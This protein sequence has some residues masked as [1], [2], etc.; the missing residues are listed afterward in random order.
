MHTNMQRAK[1]LLAQMSLKEKIAQLVSVWFEIA[2]DESITIRQ[3]FSHHQHNPLSQQEILQDGIGQLSRP[4]GT[5][6][7]DV[8]KQAASVN[9]IQKYI[10][11]STRLGIP[12]MF[13]EECL[14]GA[15]VSGATIFPSALN[16]GS[17]W[18]QTLIKEIATR[19]GKELRSLNVH[20]GLSPVLDVARDARWGRLE[21]TF[22]EDPYL[23]GVMALEYVKGLQGENQVP[24]ATI[25]HFVG[26]SASEGSRNHAPVHF[27]LNEMHNVYALPFEM[28]IKG[29]RVGSVMP[30][31][32]DID[33]IPSSA[34]KSLLDTLL[35]KEWGFD[36]LIVSDYEAIAQLVSDHHIADDFAEAAALA[37]KAGMD[38]ELP[39]FTVYIKGLE[40]AVERSLVTVDEIDAVVVRVLAEKYRQKVFEKPYVEIDAIE[41]ATNESHNL[42]V[43]VAEK[44]IVLLKNEG[45]LPLTQETK[46]ALIGPLADHPYAM[47][48]GY[49][50][51]IHLQGSSTPEQTVPKRSYTIKK[52]IERLSKAEVMYEPGCV[53]YEGS[54]ERALFFPGDVK[55]DDESQT[56]S[57][58]SDTSFISQAVKVAKQADV[59]VL[60]VGDLVGLFNQGTSGEGSDSATL[61]LPGVQEEL[62]DAVIATNKP[63]ITILVSGRPYTIHSSVEHANAIIASWL[64]GEGGGE[65]LANILFGKSNPSGKTTLSF[66]HTAGAMPFFYNHYK[67]SQGLPKQ[68]AFGAQYPFGHGLSYTT[69]TYSDVKL[70]TPTITVDGEAQVELTLTNSGSFIGDEIVQLYIRDHKASIVRPIK[71]LKGFARVSL[72]PQEYKKVVF[73]LPADHL[74]FYSGGRRIVEPGLFD[75]MVGSSS[76]V[77]AATHILEVTGELR[78]LPQ[79]WRDTT[80]VEII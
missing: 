46:I 65:A 49:T 28:V 72:K 21:E 14:T 23:C 24:L 9:K 71:E 16:Y 37:L 25:K 20:Q 31:Y 40:E 42:A 34:D 13:H 11:E 80:T 44:S 48:G 61:K 26:H 76:E 59:V 10:I 2:E 79:K 1:V 7:K 50:P 35:R 32:H 30:A 64:P 3:A 39:S 29:T 60:V 19:I 4:F 56:K 63:V 5:V 22:G 52:A 47:Y 33:G 54:F 12:A 73:T 67:K 66:P 27:G 38:V 51:P 74:S 78:V 17:T 55:D 53:L 43:E 68:K 77:L 6:A 69:F 18:D 75:V 36:G 57:L 41:L 70:T 62:M 8:K 15:M 45:A 58:S